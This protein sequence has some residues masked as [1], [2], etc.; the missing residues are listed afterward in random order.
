[1]H[2]INKFFKDKINWIS[3]PLAIVFSY[4]LMSEN[5][6]LMGS[7]VAVIVALLPMVF[8]VALSPDLAIKFVKLHKKSQKKVN[9]KYFFM[10]SK[11]NTPSTISFVLKNSLY[12][13]SI[14][15]SILNWSGLMNKSPDVWTIGILAI[16]MI[17]PILFIGSILHIS[18]VLL[19]QIG[20]MF[21]NKREGTIS[22]VG[23]E[24]NNRFSWLFSSV[25]IISFIHSAFV[26][27]LELPIFLGIILAVF[28]TGIF[29]SFFGFYFF[30][31]KH[32]VKLSQKL[33]ERI[34]KII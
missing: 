6:Y 23:S 3:I 33:K 25:L 27:E 31:K 17:M 7:F 13:I 28:V 34:K 11:I 8:S 16:I 22:K 1:M 2:L 5:L 12:T 18:S 32:L 10:N 26:N 4:G 24:F 19:N 20:L 29:S 21:E 15:Y 9:H 30:K 14:L